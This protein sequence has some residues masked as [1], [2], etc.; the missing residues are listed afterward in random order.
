MDI[1]ELHLYVRVWGC[2]IL[3]METHNK[4]E[5]GTLFTPKDEEIMIMLEKH[6]SEEEDENNQDSRFFDNDS[7]NSDEDTVESLKESRIF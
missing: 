4:L 3:E 1:H 2:P 5:Y 6:P 7:N